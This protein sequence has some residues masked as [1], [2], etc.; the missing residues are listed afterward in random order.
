MSHK[1]ESEV[2]QSKT[3]HNR[4]SL[5]ETTSQTTAGPNKGS[6]APGGP[7]LLGPIGSMGPTVK[8]WTHQTTKPL[9]STTKWNRSSALTLDTY[10][11]E[12]IGLSHRANS[13]S[14]SW[15][16]S[17]SKSHS[18]ILNYFFNF[19]FL[20]P[21]PTATAVP[22]LIPKSRIRPRSKTK[23][24][25]QQLSNHRQQRTLTLSPTKK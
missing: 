8:E 12:C 22:L 2:Y 24:Q 19:F 18:L 1:G 3:I 23:D 21:R 16:P 25:H 11:G 7:H 15:S 10:F 20:A 13:P 14:H 4:P 17:S 9:H 5:P 6:Q